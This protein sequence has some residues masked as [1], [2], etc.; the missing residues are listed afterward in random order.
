[1]DGASL[2]SIRRD[3]GLTQEQLGSVLGLSSQT[4]VRWEK[5]RG[6]P[7]AWAETILLRFESALC[8]DGEARPAHNLAQRYAAHGPVHV[9]AF[10]LS[11]TED[12]L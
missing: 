5:G 4:I 2:R 8:R 6:R 1:M 7:S 9:L 11:L 3:L 12:P 10:L